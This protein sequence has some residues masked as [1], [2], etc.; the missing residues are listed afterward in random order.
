MNL[1]SKLFIS[2]AVCLAL[3]SHTS[4]ATAN[5]LT[6]FPLR[7]D[8]STQTRTAAFNVVSGESASTLM[9]IHLFAWTQANG[10]DLLAPSDDLL[11]GPPIFTLEPGQ[12]QLVRV[13]L[14]DQPTSNR[15]VAYRIVIAEVPTTKL[16]GLSF[17]FRLSMPIF[18]SPIVPSGA[19]A[20]WTV[21]RSDALHFRITLHNSGDQHLHLVAL[22]VD[23]VPGG[24]RIFNGSAVAYVLADQRRSW[25]VPVAKAVG[26]RS[27]RIESTTEGGVLDPPVYVNVP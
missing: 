6:I 14:R 3:Y 19:H 9:Q 7:A 20:E 10:V 17:V 4:V 18:V 26:A 2:A 5:G 23:T 22:R 27:F 24:A 12:A 8:L 13:G 1:R 16:A 21:D 25:V 11:V 15:E